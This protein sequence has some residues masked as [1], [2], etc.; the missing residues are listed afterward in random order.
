MK[1]R[2]L[3]VLV[4]V[5]AAMQGQSSGPG[6]KCRKISIVLQEKIEKSDGYISQFVDYGSHRDPDSGIHVRIP[7]PFSGTGIRRDHPIDLRSSPHR[8]ERSTASSAAKWAAVA[9]YSDPDEAHIY[10]EDDGKYMD[11]PMSLIPLE[12]IG[13]VTVPLN[14]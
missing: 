2:F 7:V 6:C 4:V 12:F 1:I 8:L 10:T 14:E 9:I 5:P 13:G 11:R 3:A